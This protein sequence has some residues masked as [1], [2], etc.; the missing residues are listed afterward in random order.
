MRTLEQVVESLLKECP[1]GS[2]LKVGD[3]IDYTND[4]GTV[5]PNLEVIGFGNEKTSWGGY[6]YLKKSSYWYP[7]T[8]ESVKK[9]EDQEQTN[10]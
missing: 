1:F 9:S 3:K 5:F 10:F 6:I 4:Y 2:E 8:I 7:V